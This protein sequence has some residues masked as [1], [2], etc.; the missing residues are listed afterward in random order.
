MTAEE[1]RRLEQELTQLISVKRPEIAGKIGRAAADGDLSE[2]G[3]YHDAKEQQAH[4]EGRIAELEYVVRNAVVVEPQ[5]DAIGLG[6]LVHIKDES[7]GER[8]FR[9]VSKLS[10]RP[11][12]GLLSDE[13]PLG[14]AL[15]GHVP[16]ESVS[17]QTPA[18]QSKT[19]TILSIE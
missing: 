16:G 6:N 8:S 17:Y 5:A 11:S 7:G 14:A 1:K 18:G 13:S 9:V 10:A 12:E 15:L 3:A 2:N 4:I 19:V